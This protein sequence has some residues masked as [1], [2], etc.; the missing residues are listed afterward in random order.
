MGIVEVATGIE[1]LVV[2]RRGRRVKML[3]TR[4]ADEPVSNKRCFGADRGRWLRCI[5]QWNAVEPAGTS[6]W[7]ISRVAPL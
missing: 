6:R 3:K 1:V 4:K 5:G 2:V 7:K